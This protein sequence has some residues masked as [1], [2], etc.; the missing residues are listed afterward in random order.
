L[1]QVVKQALQN[2]GLSAAALDV[3]EMH[4][5]GTP[6]GDPIEVGAVLAVLGTSGKRSSTGLSAVKSVLGHC[7]PAAG[8]ASMW[9]MINRCLRSL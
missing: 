5:T 4:G 1:W 6:L 3:V 9:H 8:A 2:A 7:E